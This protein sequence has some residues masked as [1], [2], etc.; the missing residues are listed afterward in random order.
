MSDEQL[1][2]KAEVQQLLDLMIQAVYS[3]R[4]VFLRELLSNAAD[5]LDKVRFLALTHSD[6]VAAEGEP[7]I[8]VRVD[9]EAQTITLDDDGVGMTR[10]EAI[11]NLGTIAHSGSR[12]FFEEL[13]AQG[14]ASAPDLIGRFGVGFYSS[15]MVAS[16][17]EVVTR[18][19]LAGS[20]AVR[21]VSEGNGTFSVSEAERA[22]RG[23]TI[24][25]HLRDDASEYLEGWK[26]R[27][28]IKQHSNYLNWTVLLDG[29]AATSGKALWREAPAS[30]SDDD[31]QELYRSLSFDFEPPALRVHLSVESPLQVAAM[32]FVPKN[33]P[34]DLFNP[35][36]DKGPR[37]YVRRVLI[38]EHARDLLPD[39]LR[40]LRGVV[41]S[42]DI[43][44]NMSRELVQKTPAV[45][46]IRTTLTKRV[47]K[48]LRKFAERPLDD[49]ETKHPYDGVWEAFGVLLKEGYYHD[50]LT[51]GDELLP[52][53]RFQTHNAEAGVWQGLE[54][55]KA[56]LPEGQDALW[57]VTA[58]TR[59]S[60]LR[61]PHLEAFRKKGW[62]VLLLT[63]PV[64]EWF[65]QTLED[66]DGM[67]LKS[68]SRGD[69]QLEDEEATGD[70]AD[71]TGLAPWMST[72]LVDEVASVRTSARLTESPAALVDDENGMSA[73]MERLLRAARQDVGESKRHLE[74]NPSHPI[75]RHLAALHE[76]G[77]TEAAEPLARLLYDDALLLEG[78]VKDA[79]GLARR[80]SALLEQAAAA[81]L[82]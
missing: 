43:P 54:A 11:T 46:Q 78:T 7:S 68:V 29:E 22:H 70:K 81:A 51:F 19:A 34:Y 47:L 9:K 66:F 20:E 14:A 73:N 30:V 16:R 69:L 67:P 8:R 24:T 2:F 71:L 15:F 23:T 40:F 53:L 52:L 13:K 4:D 27:Q 49:G 63:D 31:A 75:V 17:V 1:G 42:D 64:D 28:I 3:N 58:D 6:L 10:E 21:W 61:S 38:D 80:L 33:R 62:T 32:L 56:S 39:W 57:Y 59:E 37:L 55:I 79:A 5:A 12:R 36:S 48:E 26:V 50:K 65:I 72:L 60:A 77:R 44:L 76:A 18:S 74:L 35:E 82:A 41:D 45:R 25:L